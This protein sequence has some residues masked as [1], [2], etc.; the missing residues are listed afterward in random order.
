MDPNSQQWSPFVQPVQAPQQPYGAISPLPGPVAQQYTPPP[1]FASY[2]NPPQGFVAPTPQ[3]YAGNGQPVHLVNQPGS[4]TPQPQ[5]YQPQPSYQPPPP[6]PPPQPQGPIG[7]VTYQQPPAP[8]PQPQPYQTQPS[9]YLLGPDGRPLSPQQVP[10]PQQPQQPQGLQQGPAQQQDNPYAQLGATVAAALGTLPQGQ[11]RPAWQPPDFDP[12]QIPNLFVSDPRTGQTVVR[13]GADP[14]QVAKAQQWLNWIDDWENNQFRRNPFEAL[15]PGLEDWTK[16]IAR[17][18]YQETIQNQRDLQ[19]VQSFQS[20]NWDW[21]YQ[22][23]PDR[24]PVANPQQPGG[25]V[26]SPVGQQ[27]A[28]YLARVESMGVKSGAEQLRIAQAMFENDLARRAAQTP[29]TPPPSTGP[30]ALAALQQQNPMAA[31]QQAIF[32]PGQFMQAPAMMP[33]FSPMPQAQPQYPGV[34]FDAMAAGAA[35]PMP[36]GAGFLP[37]STPYV[38][39]AP[40]T[41]AANGFSAPSPYGLTFAQALERGAIAQGIMA[42]NSGPIPG[43]LF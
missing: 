30:A 5:P 31:S 14:M 26:L 12:R 18:V 9:Q 17:T 4:Y 24:R 10:Q 27:F 8:Q 32:A 16:Q 19:E 6:Q 22:L 34:S 39:Q 15:K 40:A 1:P 29:A 41:A 42:P 25:F 2:S 7:P 13:P 20:R 33:G 21:L 36:P 37:G 43:T 23:G 28:G 3:I 38:G 35:P 11:Q